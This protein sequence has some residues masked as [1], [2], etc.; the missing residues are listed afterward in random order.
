MCC[1]LFWRS[2]LFLNGNELVAV[3]TGVIVIET[4]IHVEGDDA[5][6]QP[7][8]EA[9]EEEAHQ[10]GESATLGSDLSGTGVSAR[11]AM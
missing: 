5:A 8:A 3:T 1:C 11:A 10:P 2:A 7:A 6:T 4:S 9:T